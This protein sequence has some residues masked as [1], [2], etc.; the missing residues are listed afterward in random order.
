MVSDDWKSVLLHSLEAD[1]CAVWNVVSAVAEDKVGILPSTA[2]HRTDF[3]G[4]SA[5]IGRQIQTASVVLLDI[6]ATC[7]DRRHYIYL[8]TLYNSF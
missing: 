1:L 8:N 3:A 7:F 4:L 2:G 5:S 6:S